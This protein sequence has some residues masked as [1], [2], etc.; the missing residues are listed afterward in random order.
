MP[1]KRRLL[2]A[3]RGQDRQRL[4]E[5]AFLAGAE[6]ISI[7]SN[8]RQYA[9]RHTQRGA[10][11]AAPASSISEPKPIKQCS[12]RVGDIGDVRIASGQFPDQEALYG[13]ESQ[14]A[15]FGAGSG[16]LHIVEHPSNFGAGKIGIDQQTGLVLNRRLMTR[17]AQSLARLGRATVL[18]D[19]CW[20]DGFARCAIPDQRRLTLVGDTNPGN[21]VHTARLGDRF[22]ADIHRLVPDLLA[23][24]LDPTII[25]IGQRHFLLCERDLIQ[26]AVKYNR[27]RGSGA[28]I[29]DENIVAHVACPSVFPA[30][31]TGAMRNVNAPCAALRDR[32]TT[33]GWLPLRQRWK[34]PQS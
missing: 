12:R 5:E 6:I 34:F 2:I 21:A 8:L 13:S 10:H 27:S 29:N 3:R 11:L 22:T 31:W 23:V 1:H 26:I 7:L 24:L 19:D 16:T 4:A 9:H 18:P 30:G 20:R 33:R 32:R 14:F 28:L 15:C 25:R 17:L